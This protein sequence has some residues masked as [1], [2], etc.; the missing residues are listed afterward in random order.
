[1]DVT[2]STRRDVHLA[3]DDERLDGGSPLRILLE[4]RVEHGV[5]DLIRDLVGV[6]FGDA[7]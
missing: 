2:I 1:L 4:D 6:A 7:F 3:G 5:R